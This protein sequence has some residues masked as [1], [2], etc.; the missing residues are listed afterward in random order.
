MPSIKGMTIL[1]IG[2][3][4]GIG[5][6]VA[7]KSLSEGAI[8]HI[9][10][11]NPSRVSGSS[12]S[13]QAKFPNGQITGHTCDLSGDDV[14]AQLRSLLNAIGQLDHIVFTAGDSLS[15][16][17]I[18]NI[19]LETIH[20]A[21][22][23]RFVAP[24]LLAKLAPQYLKPTHASSLIFT[25]GAVADKPIPGWSVVAGYAAGLHGMVR[26]LAVDLKPLR[27]NLVSSGPVKTPLID[28]ALDAEQLAKW[29]ILGKI[30][31]VEE[32][33]EAYSYLMKDTNATGSST[34]S[35]MDTDPPGDPPHTQDD[36]YTRSNKSKFRFKRPSSK[37]R[38]RSK[39]SHHDDSHRRHRHHRTKRHKHR[40]SSQRSASPDATGPAPLPA[41]DAFRESLFDALGD[42]EGAAYW[43][44]VYGQPIH[45]YPVPQVPGPNGELEQMTDEEYAAYVRSR[46]WERT[47][48]GMLEE[49]E[50]LRAERARQ[51]RREQQREEE[52]RRRHGFE[53]DMEACLAR[54]RERRRAKAWKGIWE[55][56]VRSWE[57]VDKAA[58]DAA[59]ASAEDQG[60][61]KRLRN[62][63]FWPV[64]SG[65]RRDVSRDAVRE[66]MRHVPSAS[67][68]D[69]AEL[70]AV[71]KAERVRWHPD[72]MQ[73]RYGVL[74]IDEA[75]MRSVTEVFQ[76]VDHMW[77]EA[78]EKR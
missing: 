78:R 61:G 24:L 65:K 59:A 48:E 33:A 64:E 35:A 72:K 17:P 41:E 30:G 32:L 77:S 15:L 71:L 31:T 7:E 57:E 38:A 16:V 44:S 4:S 66:F 12:Q 68:D 43:E 19:S 56:Y 9:A 23:V 69:D 8:V 5:Y 50:R 51:R 29:S 52:M 45:T 26:N 27:V 14:E 20:K 3:S 46:M 36:E 18:N 37:R 58:A 70:L 62:L 73:H 67:E 11:S 54:G 34:P 42:D 13:L 60:E 75:V 47:R 21:G 1:V 6:G 53:R 2:G 25:T 49:Q 10:S 63:L 74:G 55:E 28:G 39:H 22:R 76:I 40:S